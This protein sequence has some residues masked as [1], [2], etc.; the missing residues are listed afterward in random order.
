MGHVAAL[1]VCSDVGERS[2]RAERS[3]Q[4]SKGKSSDNFGLIGPRLVTRDE[5]PDPGICTCGW[6]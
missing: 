3:G 2:F 5:V 6:R 1:F 4:W